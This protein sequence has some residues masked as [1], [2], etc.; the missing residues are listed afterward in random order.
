MFNKIVEL[1]EEACEQSSVWVRAWLY[2]AVG[3]DLWL[4]LKG[5]FGNGLESDVDVCRWMMGA[6]SV[7][8]GNAAMVRLGIGGSKLKMVI[9]EQ[10]RWVLLCGMEVLVLS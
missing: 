6:F 1:L 5:M 2:G 7:K 9:L 10:I 4:L 3:E 8:E